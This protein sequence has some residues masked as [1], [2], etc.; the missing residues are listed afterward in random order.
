ML[1]FKLGTLQGT[2]M[3]AVLNINPVFLYSATQ[4]TLEDNAKGLTTFFGFGT[5]F[6]EYTV[7][8]M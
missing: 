6:D 2:Q 5:Q 4:I 3:T 1:K 8:V 7:E